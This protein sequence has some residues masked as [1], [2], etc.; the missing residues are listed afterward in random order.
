M[1]TCPPLPPE[2]IGLKAL[3]FDSFG[4]LHVLDSFAAKVA[5][6]N[7]VTGEFIDGYGEYGEG[8]A[9][10][11]LPADVFVDSSVSIITDGETNNIE[12]FIIP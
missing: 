9:L 8:Q 6:L 5:I 11:K 10:L 3:A 12:F 1:G 4:R 7:P 2:F